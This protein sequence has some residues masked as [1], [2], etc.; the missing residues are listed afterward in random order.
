MIL[1]ILQ[2]ASNC[3]SIYDIESDCYDIDIQMGTDYKYAVVAPSYY[4]LKISRHK[5]DDSALKALLKLKKMGYE[6]VFLIDRNG[7]NFDEHYRD[8]VKIEKRQSVEII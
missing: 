1:R 8:L 6:N 3:G 7:D 2:K 5:S 4:N